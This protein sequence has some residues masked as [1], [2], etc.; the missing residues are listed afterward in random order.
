LFNLIPVFPLDGEKV[1]DYLLPP[2]GARVLE[3]IRPY[4]PMILMVLLFILPLAGID[5]IG[6]VIQPALGF[7][8]QLLI[9]A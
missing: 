4:G 9:G 8:T 3:S 7:L 2:S 6:K 5:V 1:L